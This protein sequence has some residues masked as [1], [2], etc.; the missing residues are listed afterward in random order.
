MTALVGCT[1]Q[2]VGAS[3]HPDK[4]GLG[5]GLS[6]QGSP[7]GRWQKSFQVHQLPLL[8]LEG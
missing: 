7:G 6:A 5:R 8:G 3:L 2:G 4:P 1:L